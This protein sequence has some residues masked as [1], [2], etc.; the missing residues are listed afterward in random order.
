MQAL[1][2]SVHVKPRNTFQ[3]DS[4]YMSFSS[5]QLQIAHSIQNN[6]IVCI[7]VLKIFLDERCCFKR[8]LPNL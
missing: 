3:L 2:V 4:L 6:E 7:Y 1:V 8:P 5:C